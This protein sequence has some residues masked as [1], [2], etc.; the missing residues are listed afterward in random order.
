MSSKSIKKLVFGAVFCAIIFALTAFLQIPSQTGYIHIGDAAVFLVAS[1]LPAPIAA[2]AAAVGAAGADLFS[3][4]TLWAPATFFIKGISA[5]FFSSKEEKIIK[6]RNILAL[7]ASCALCLGG[8]YLYEAFLTK[9]FLTPVASI[10]GN[11]MQCLFSAAI[12]LIAGLALDRIGAVQNF[13]R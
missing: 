10:A 2:V 12:Y 8:Y 3:G 9:S 1:L 6:P 4:F 11:A 5:F 13:R 7:I